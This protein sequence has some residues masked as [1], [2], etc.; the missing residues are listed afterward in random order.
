MDNEK[1]DVWYGNA[2]AVLLEIKAKQKTDELVVET[3][4]SVE[5]CDDCS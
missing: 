5:K 2:R 1:I 4:G 3:L